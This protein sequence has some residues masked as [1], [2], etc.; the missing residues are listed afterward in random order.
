MTPRSNCFDSVGESGTKHE[1]ISR[2]RYYFRSDRFNK[3]GL[4][5]KLLLKVFKICF[6]RKIL[7]SGTK[8][9][10]S[11][12]GYYSTQDCYYALSDKHHRQVR[13]QLRRNGL[14]NPLNECRVHK[15]AMQRRDRR[16]DLVRRLP[17]IARD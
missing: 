6:R 14:C 5:L 9:F 12:C 7:A 11:K 17:F 13:G 15:S 4:L 1:S 8:I 16:P 3:F 2:S 10:T